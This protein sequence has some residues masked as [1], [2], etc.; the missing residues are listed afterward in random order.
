MV[1]IY[2]DGDGILTSHYRRLAPRLEKRYGIKTIQR[3]GYYRVWLT[4]GSYYTMITDKLKARDIVKLACQNITPDKIP[5]LKELPKKAVQVQSTKQDKN[6]LRAE[7][8][9]NHTVLTAQQ[10]HRMIYDQ[11]PQMKSPYGRQ[12]SETLDS[13]YI[14][15]SETLWL[16]V[17]KHIGMPPFKYLADMRDCEDY[18]RWLA[19]KCPELLDIN[20]CGM[21]IDNSIGHGYNAL[22]TPT[23]ILYCEP[24]TMRIGVKS[25]R[26]IG[27]I[28]F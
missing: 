18:S 19:A 26:K 20:G 11:E 16:K 1:T 8:K 4:A 12:K 14:A 9:K 17:L 23:G 25:D 6:P 13:R 22:L 21:V 15:I 24:Q 27:E 7:I 28:R 2:L 3:K 10:V 5:P